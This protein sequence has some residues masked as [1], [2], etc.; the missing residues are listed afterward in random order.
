[1]YCVAGRKAANTLISQVAC[2][3]KLM[4][5]YAGQKPLFV[6]EKTEAAGV[7]RK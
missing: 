4:K 5:E 3:A 7:C 6:V 2:A 1:M